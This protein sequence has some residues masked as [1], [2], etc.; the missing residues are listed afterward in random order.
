MLDRRALEV[1]VFS[2]VAEALA[3]TDL[4]VEDS[5]EYADYRKQLLS[6]DECEKRLPEYCQSLGLPT[7]STALVASLKEQLTALASQIDQKFPGNG[8]FSIDDDGTQHL[9]QQKASPLP[10]GIDDFKT[11]VYSRMPERH[12]LDILKDV[13]HWSNYTKH[14]GPPSGSDSKMADAASRYLFTVFG[15]G[16]NLGANQTARHAPGNIN[17]QNL[18]RINAQHINAAKLEA[19]LNDV[20]NQYSRFE[21]PGF[22]G[23]SNVAIADGTQ[24]ELRKNTLMGEQHRPS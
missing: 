13:Q 8:E 20:I 18:L 11:E 22:W 19:A 21:L 14:F 9:K 10:E 17:P 16:C 5:G 12:L 6:L 24:M 1:C 15:Y 3:G 7:S 4:Y 23:K 2:H